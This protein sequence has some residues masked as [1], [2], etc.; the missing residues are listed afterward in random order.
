[1]DAAGDLFGT[2]S[3]GGTYGYGTVFEIVKSGSSYSSTPTVLVSFSG[4]NGA[5]P[6][7]GLITDA[8]GDLFGTTYDGGASSDGT[9]FEIVKNGSSYSSTPTVLAT[10]NGTNGQNPKASLIVDAAGDLLGT[11]VDGGGNGTLFEIA[12]S[13]SGYSSTPTTLAT[14]NSTNGRYPLSGLI[15]DAAGD[16]LGTTG[17]GGANG[18]GEVFELAALSTTPIAT[19]DSTTTVINTDPPVPPT[20]AI[21]SA[22]AASNIPTQTLATTD[23]GQTAIPA[24]GGAGTTNDL[25]FI[26]G[27]TDQNLWFLQ[28]GNDLKIDVLGTNTSVTTT[29]WFSSSAN[30]LQEISAGSL[31]IDSQVSQLVQAMATYAANNPGF[32]PTSPS[33]S[34]VPNDTSLQNSLA[35]AW[36]S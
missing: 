26:G 10:F 22:A 34:A 28:S 36:H 6:Y 19:V 24:Q 32:D 11:T 14:F 1:M 2:S 18:D 31:K 16:L 3:S 4:S 13:G 15:M 5:N 9:V 30:Q 33:I 17:Q 8:A 27:I 23:S 25:D 29:G 12:K 20:V 35:A 21:T 7:G